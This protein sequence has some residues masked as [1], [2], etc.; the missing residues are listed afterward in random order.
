MFSSVWYQLHVF[1]RL[2]PATCFPALGT[3]YMFSRVWYQL[4]VFP[5]LVPVACFPSLAPCSYLFSRVWHKSH[6]L[7]WLHVFPRLGPVT[8]FN[9]PWLTLVSRFPALGTAVGFS[10]TVAKWPAQTGEHGAGTCCNDMRQ[11]SVHKGACPRDMPSSVC[12]PLHLHAFASS[13]DWF[14]ASVLI[15][16]DRYTGRGKRCESGL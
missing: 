12:Q 2:V 4:H 1:P 6:V 3:S 9:L 14:R 15:G 8:C 7:C 5:R 13:P 10:S 11:C 16:I